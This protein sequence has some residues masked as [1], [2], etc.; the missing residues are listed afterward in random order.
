MHSI[1]S[2]QKENILSLA[3]N[4]HS[5]CS[6]ASKLGVSQSTVSRILRNLLLIDLDL[7]LVV[8]PSFHLLLSM[9]LSLKSPQAELPMLS[10]LP[11]TSILSFLVQSPHKQ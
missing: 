2:A 1:A 8:L 4:G 9:L 3:S 6:I 11:T 7:F 5:S 10:K